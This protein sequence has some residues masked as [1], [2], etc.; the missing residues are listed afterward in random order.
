MRQISEVIASKSPYPF[1]QPSSV[2]DI[3]PKPDGY[4]YAKKRAFIDELIVHKG[5]VLLTRSGSIGRAVYVSDTLDNKILSHDMLRI[6]CN[7]PE[8]A[9]YIYTYL[10]S[11]A[12]QKILKSYTY[13]AVI[14]HIEAEHLNDIPVP[15]APE[16]L[17]RKIHE[18]VVRSYALRDDS[19]LMLDEAESLLVREL[20]L[21]PLDSIKGGDNVRCFEVDSWELGGRFEA[22]YHSLVFGEIVNVLKENTAEVVT[23][24]DARVSRRILLPGRFKR[25]YVGEGYGAV[26]IGGK[27]IGELDPADKKYLAFSQHEDRIREE[28]T[29][30]E[31]MILITCSGTIGNAALV[32]EHWDG[33]TMTHDIIRL[34]PASGD[35]AGYTYVFLASEWGRELIRRYTYG[36]VVEHI[37]AEHAAAVPFPLMRDKDVQGRINALALGANTKRTEAYR[38]EREALDLFTREILE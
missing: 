32:P 15:Y 26:F 31:G 10:K 4:L 17:R 12:G 19:N 5:Q 18:L 8:D 33:W 16:E 11:P 30:H 7:I 6:N 27:Q 35:T 38:L 14:P 36:A 24:G 21:P 22:S 20:G 1:Y 37:E 29:I 34:L 25:V 3:K 2:T 23:V 9:G 28:L 13:G